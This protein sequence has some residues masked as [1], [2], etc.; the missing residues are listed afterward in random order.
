MKKLGPDTN[1]CDLN[2]N[3]IMKPIFDNLTEEDRKAL[4]ACHKEVDELFLSPYEVTWQGLIQ[5]DATFI[6]IRKDEATPK[7][8]SNLSLSLDVVRSMINST[9]ECQVK[10]NNELTGI[11]IEERDRKHLYSLMCI[12]ILYLAL[13]ILLKPILDQVAHR[14]TA[15]HNQTHQ[16][17]Q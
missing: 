10:S 16:P 11:L 5:T 4:E 8:R 13:L 7:V 15:R 6:I 1:V 3:N 2:K 14:R 9:L 17:N 12:I